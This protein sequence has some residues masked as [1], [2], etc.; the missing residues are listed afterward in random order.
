MFVS[1][2][3]PSENTGIINAGTA[4]NT[5]SHDLV[6]EKLSTIE[7]PSKRDIDVLKYHDY[8]GLSPLKNT[9][10]SFLTKY[11]KAHDQLDPDKLVVLNGCGPCIT[12]LTI[13]LSDPGD[14]WLMTTP[15]YS[16]MKN[17]VGRLPLAEIVSVDLCS[18]TSGENGKPFQLTVDKLEDALEQATQKGINVRGLILINPHNPL[19]DIYSKELL[20]DCLHFAKR[21]ELHVIADE[22]YMFSVFDE[23][24]EFT[25]VLSLEDLPDP[26]R[27]HFTW[28][29]SKDFCMSGVRCGVI[30]SWNKDVV[31]A[32]SGIA[33]WF[34]VPTVMQVTL[35]SMLCDEEWVAQTYLPTN[36]KRLRNA[37]EVMSKGLAKIGI[38]HLARSAGLYIWA[39][40]RKLVSPLTFEAELEVFYELIDTGVYIAPGQAYYCKE[41]GWFR[42]VFALPRDIQD[43]EDV[44]PFLRRID[45]DVITK[46]IP[47][48]DRISPKKYPNILFVTA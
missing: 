7:P 47:F 20:M 18:Q 37:H 35:K 4:E 42:I 26:D 39:D 9:L 27:T 5:I 46:Y 22:I 2:N 17:D 28:S 44:R 36:R 31:S 6:A 41:P 45:K 23:E 12:A 32:L 30:Y 21:H 16:S 24:A 11:S 48:A 15:Y 33:F 10:C 43:Q 3:K 1:V 38:P 25:S 40:F 29:F 8:T 14:A 34:S 13:V 19:G